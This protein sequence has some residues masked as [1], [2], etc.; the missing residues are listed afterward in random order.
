MHIVFLTLFLGLV[1]GPQTVTL[2][3]EDR[4]ASIELF[5]DG[6]SVGRMTGPPWS[7]RVDSG[8]ELLPHRL[9]ARAVGRD[10]VEAGRAEQWINLPRPPAE[11]EIL[12]AP[13]APGM[14]GAQVHW[15]SISGERPSAVSLRL[16][17]EP[18]PL[19]AQSRAVIAIPAAGS[20]RV[21]AAELRF[22]GGSPSAGRD[23]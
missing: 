5:L 11:A 14:V 23:C 21:L 9:E 13:A 20:A 8:P 22:A 19:D 4:A 15:Q 7:R 16:D 12:L 6:R 10:G 17:G 2:A 3:A 18:L 1:R